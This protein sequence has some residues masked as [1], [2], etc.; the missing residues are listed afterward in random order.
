MSCDDT[1]GDDKTDEA[2]WCSECSEYSDCSYNWNQN[3]SQISV[4]TALSEIIKGSWF[5]L[6]SINNWGIAT[7]TS[8]GKGL[9][10]PSHITYK[11]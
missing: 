1:N 6:A 3:Q 8:A 2:L 4:E 9:Q 7:L 5:K 11:W 10:Q